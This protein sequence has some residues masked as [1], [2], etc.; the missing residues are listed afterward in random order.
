[1][2]AFTNGKTSRRN[3]V[4]TARNTSNLPWV[5][6]ALKFLFTAQIILAERSFEKF[7]PI[8]NEQNEKTPPVGADEVEWLSLVRFAR[9]AHIALSRENLA[10]SGDESRH[11]SVTLLACE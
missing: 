10:Q 1:M 2:L 8:E 7:S 3:A 11:V 9:V 5:K 4:F 6:I